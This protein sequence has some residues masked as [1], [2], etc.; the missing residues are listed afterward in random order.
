MFKRLVVLVTLLPMLVHSIFGCCWHH[1]HF[2]HVDVCETPS[3]AADIHRHQ[4]THDH[5][6]GSANAETPTSNVPAPCKHQTPCDEVRCVFLAAT[7]HRFAFA[8]ELTAKFVVPEANCSVTLRNSLVSLRT[9]TASRE[10]PT[11]QEHCALIQVW[12]V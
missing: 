9:V 5:S 2:D 4:C 1:A 8:F 6:W 11:S 12:I 7:P 3:V 10:L